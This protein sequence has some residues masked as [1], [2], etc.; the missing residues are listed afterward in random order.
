MFCANR[1]NSPVFVL[2]M[3]KYHKQLCKL[4]RNGQLIIYNFYWILNI[5]SDCYLCWMGDALFLD[6]SRR[7]SGK[8]MQK[9]LFVDHHEAGN[10]MVWYSIDLT[11]SIKICGW[12]SIFS[13]CHW[14]KSISYNISYFNVHFRVNHSFLKRMGND[15]CGVGFLAIINIFILDCDAL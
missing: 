8:L 12:L 4:S 1:G 6:G 10:G 5:R 14:R 11:N 9:K 7:E 15:A 2:S 3:G 13:T